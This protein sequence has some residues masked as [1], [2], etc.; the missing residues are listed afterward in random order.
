MSEEL[1]WND[2]LRLASADLAA[3]GIAVVTIDG[4][5]IR[6]KDTF[7]DEFAR[8]LKFPDYFGKNWDAFEECL[9]DLA[10]LQAGG[11]LLIYRD[12]GFFRNSRPDE[13]A[14]ASGIILD[15]VEHWKVPGFSFKVLFV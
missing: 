11:L 8:E 10:W 12:S 13:W 7:L 4:S 14:I 15:A 1:L 6:D 2:W 3:R 9:Q 5:R